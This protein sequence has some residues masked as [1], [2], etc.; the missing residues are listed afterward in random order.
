MTAPQPAPD[1]HSASSLPGEA[2]PVSGASSGDWRREIADALRVAV[3]VAVLGGLVLGLLWVWLAPRVPLVSD[4]RAVLLANSEGQQAV[5][6][7]GVF[8]LVGL[9]VGAVAG[10]VV[11]LMRRGGGVAVALGLAGGALAGSW[12]AWQLGMWL[13]PS[14]DIVA[15]ARSAGV[16]NVFEAPLE[17]GAHGVLLALPFAAVGFHLPT[18]LSPPPTRPP[19]FPPSSPG[20]TS[21]SPRAGAGARASDAGV[22][23]LRAIPAVR[24]PVNVIRSAGESSISSP[25]RPAETKTVGC[26]R[27]EA[28]TTVRSRLRCPSGEMPPRT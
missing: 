15:A 21:G 6:A 14:D 8:L 23:Q 22:A 7:D 10:I 20:G 19:P 13:G 18:A 27:A 1:H 24:A 4:G 11:F 12:L 25:R 9:G 3:P 28:S 26:S 16:D 2:P 5:A 17:L